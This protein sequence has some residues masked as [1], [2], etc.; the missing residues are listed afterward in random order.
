MVFLALAILILHDTMVL[1]PDRHNSC[2]IIGLH[3]R[4]A[5]VLSLHQSDLW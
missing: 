4:F 1:S 3:V 5:L 2:R